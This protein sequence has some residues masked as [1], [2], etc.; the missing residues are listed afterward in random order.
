MCCGKQENSPGITGTAKASPK[1]LG[2][3]MHYITIDSM[4]LL[5]AQKN[6]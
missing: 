3:W 6:R 5:P 1:L 4:L 2:F